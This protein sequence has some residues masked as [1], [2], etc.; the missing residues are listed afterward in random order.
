MTG[1]EYANG[2]AAFG[3]FTVL[4]GAAFLF[5]LLSIV[6]VAYLL[7]AFVT[8][9]DK[10][11]IRVQ[12]RLVLAGF[13]AIVS[14][15][16]CTAL[17][18][19]RIALTTLSSTQIFAIALSGFF[20]AIMA[21]GFAMASW[22]AFKDTVLGAVAEATTQITCMV[23]IILI[24]AAFFSLVFRNL[25]GEELVADL[26][27]NLPGGTVGAIIAVMLLMFF[28]GFF[29]DFLEIVFVVVPLVTPIL[30]IMEMPDGGT[31][32]PIWLGIMMAV[33]LQTSFLTPPFGFALF[34]LRG[35]APSSVKTSDIYFGI[36][37]FVLIQILALVMLWFFPSLATW[38]PQVVYG[39]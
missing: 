31:M 24:G 4:P 34:Y 25:G 14:T 12:S 36:I 2:F 29:L 7:F 30:L 21:L 20:C 22:R 8:D 32:S 35:V 27:A 23:F 17:F 5:W 18:D 33:N 11:S 28:L 39:N 26:L 6:L 15:L 10:G 9:K 3:F 1:G 16:G 38:L 13:L 37:P 19:M